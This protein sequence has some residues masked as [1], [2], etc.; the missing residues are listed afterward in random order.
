MT[1][2]LSRLSFISAFGM[3]TRIMSQFEKTRKVSGPRALQPSQWGMLCPADTPEGE[4]R[5][6]EGTGVDMN[7][8]SILGSD[9]D[10]VVIR[11]D[12]SNWLPRCAQ[13]TCPRLDFGII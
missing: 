5:G 4:V 2:V 9:M 11:H 1:Q 10:I 12:S 3:M 6:G 13:P 8:Y 7:C